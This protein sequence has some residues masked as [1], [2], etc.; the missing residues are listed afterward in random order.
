M[1]DLWTGGPVLWRTRAHHAALTVLAAWGPVHALW[2][3]PQDTDGPVPTVFMIHGGPQAADEDRYSAVRAVW[4][5]AF[6]DGFK[7][8]EQVDEL[9][10]W[11]RS[12]RN[13]A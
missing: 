1:D 2:T 13:P 12:A 4:V 11:A 7:P 9:V 10:A 6:H 3:R 8:P 5:D